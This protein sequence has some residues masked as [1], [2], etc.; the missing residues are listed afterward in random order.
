MA[1]KVNA[2]KIKLSVPLQ[3]LSR[4]IEEQGFTELPITLEQSVQAG[5]LPLHHRDPFDRLLVAQAQVLDLPIASADAE[6][7][8]Y[9]VTRLW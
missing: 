1:I 5:L 9:Q 8:R 7:D 4:T 2:G 6:L 3:D